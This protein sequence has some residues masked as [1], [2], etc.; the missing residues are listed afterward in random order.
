MI[1]HLRAIAARLRGLFGNKRTELELDD[2]IKAHLD[3][4]I[5]RYIRQ[6]MTADE[7][8]WAA[9]RQFG[10]VT[11]L[12]EVNREMR[13]IR[14]VGT[15]FQDLRYGGRMLVKSPGFTLLTIFTLAFG[16]GANT[17]VFS[18]INGVLL[19]PLPYP[20]PERLARVFTSTRNFHKFPMS[21]FNFMDYREQNTVFESFACYV[22]DDLQLP[23]EEGAER[24]FGMRISS[25]FFRTLRIPLTLGREFTLDE[26]VPSEK[27]VVVLSHGLWRRR[28]GGDPNIIGK[29]IRLSGRTFT[30]VGVAPAGLQHVGGGYRPLPHGE[31]VDIWWPVWLS[32]NRAW[33][34][35]VMNAI[36]RLKPG[37]T[38]AQAEAEFNTMAGQLAK[39]ELPGPDWRIDIQLLSKEITEPPRKA[40]LALLAA[41][42]C[43][44]L[45]ACVNTANLMLARSVVREREI[46]VRAALGAGRARIVRQLLTESLLLATLGGLAGLPLAKLAVYAL[47]RLGPTELPRLDMIGIDGRILSFAL[48]V[49]LL[50]G[51][52]FGMAPALQSLK[53][54]LNELLKEGARGASGGKRQKQLRDGMVIAEVAL[55]FMLLIG[56]GLLMRSFLKLRQVDPGFRPEGVLTMGVFFPHATWMKAE[57]QVAFYQRL[58]ERVSALPGVRSA[59][60][61]SDLPWT[62]YENKATFPVEGKT[63]PPNQLP[64]AG[65]HFISADYLRAIGTPLV[66]G[67]WFD[68]Y[69]RSGTEPVI[70]IN[71]SMARKY[72]PGEDAIG[73]RI[74]LGDQ[75]PPKDQDWTRVVGIIGDVK[76]QPDSTQ[77]APSFYWPITQQP[78]PEMSLAIRVDKDPLSL[79]DAVRREVRSL[80]KDVAI[81]DVKTLETI[82]ATALTGQRFTLLIVGL[83]AMAA[84][85][86]AAIG[87]Y[88]VT[89]YLV[90]QRTREI[91]IR[92][93]LGAQGADVVKFVVGQGMALTLVGISLGLAGAFAV[94]H[95][96][97]TLLFS[98][99][100]TDP[101]TFALIALLLTS[102]AL[103]ACYVPA[104]RAM[105]VDP[106]QALRHE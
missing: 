50:T 74:A 96:M 94:T 18:V 11:L 106:L 36:G 17:A 26:E 30:V 87:I 67:R 61:T 32:R 20:E 101:L 85:I 72:W 90:S 97:T 88:G 31:S 65:Y 16:I 23:R 4:L 51:L 21:P 35:H 5:D 64:Q 95:F 100:P 56:A 45:I 37:V 54:N 70:L 22:R 59:G 83:F 91:G 69:D 75:N 57:E 15:L 46:V 99:S 9:R 42:F 103:L 8:A 81:T 93:A 86:L 80:N 12:Q 34:G 24:L 63:F 71:Q 49:S 25:G 7:A 28:F 82:T 29:T 89:S 38:Q 77:A 62:G 43:V 53:L 78:Y 84:I 27:T 13:G 68:A 39:K 19:K 48:G 98:V 2:E 79:V 66:A 92:L 14:L 102:V 1:H 6:G 47:I 104:R 76:D 52:L 58:V 41:V 105:K 40:L 55:A 3:L 10:N 44:L 33:G 73:K 60:L